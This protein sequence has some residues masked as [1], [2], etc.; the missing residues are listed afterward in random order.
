[1]STLTHYEELASPARPRSNS[2]HVHTH[3]ASP[4][5]AHARTLTH[6]DDTSSRGHSKFGRKKTPAEAGVCAAGTASGIVA[7]VLHDA[8]QRRINLDE[9]GDFC[10]RGV[11]QFRAKRG[12]H[13]VH[14]GV[15]VDDQTKPTGF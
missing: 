12:A 10:R 2:A 1:M 13:L 8:I 14:V 7:D 4:A 9:R 15:F 3:P 11:V 6:R 5:D